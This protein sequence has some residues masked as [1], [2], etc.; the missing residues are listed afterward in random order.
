MKKHIIHSIISILSFCLLLSCERRTTGDLVLSNINIIGVE[1]GETMLNMD[2]VI[3]DDSI[4]SVI[5][6]GNKLKY[7]AEKIVNCTDKYIIPGLWDMHV[8]LSTVGEESIPLF[9]LNGVTGVRDMGG[10][11]SK[12]KE[13]RKF[14]DGSEQYKFPKIKSAG[15]ILESPQFYNL[16]KQ[17]LGPEFVKDRI[18]ISSAEQANWIIDSLKTI[19]VDLIK[20]RTA[21]SQ[22]IFQAIASSS[23]RNDIP[24]TGH[25]DQNIDINVAIRNGI[26]TIEHDQFLQTLSLNKED[27]KRILET[28]AESEVGFT[29]TLLATYN[30]R[31]RPKDELNQLI[32]DTLNQKIPELKYLSPRLI[33]SWKIETQIKAFEAPM[34]WDSLLVPLRSFAKSLAEQTM[35]LAG[36]DCGVQGI[37][38][39]KGIH[40]ELIMLVEEMGLSNLEAIQAATINAVKNLELK[41]EY[42]S[43]EVG[44]KADLLI[45]HEN[46]LVDISNSAKIF[47]V[48]KNGNLLGNEE[49]EAE[50][51]NIAEE[52][53]IKNQSYKPK[54]L[55]FLEEVLAKMRSG[56]N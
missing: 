40:E 43:V 5:P 14:G 29:P 33:E 55:N 35:V 6:H 8:H 11:W 37:I 19:G 48:V 45:L 18:A 3:V 4:K 22:D 30:S 54:T 20:V 13:W 31:L 52:V 10:N 51:K 23:K 53:R 2:I 34:N 16:L 38:P 7:D 15:P 41:G 27:L 26:K 49:I 56:S 21:A 28:A 1:S 24:F 25:I 17:I 50:L 42:G 47:S 44:K 9:V 12:L 32:S 39:G 36:T 46:P